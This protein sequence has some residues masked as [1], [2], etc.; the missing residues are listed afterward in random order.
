[1]SKLCHDSGIGSAHTNHSLRATSITRMYNEN[2]PEK[3]IA[4]KSG[5]KSIKG[6]RCY[7][8]TSVEQQQAAGRAISGISKEESVDNGM[9]KTSTKA[10][11]NQL[12]AFS[13]GTLNNCTINITYNK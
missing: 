1:M 12:Q 9:V 3:M 7:E 2:I 5:H 4:E 10:A 13:G 6:L 8:R 11:D